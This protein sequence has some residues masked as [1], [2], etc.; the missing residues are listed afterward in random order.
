MKTTIAV[1][2]GTGKS[3]KYLVKQ[4]LQK[5]YTIRVL[6][7]NPE[8][9]PE[10]RPNQEI[11]LGD[12]RDVETVKAVLTGCDAVI[13]TLGLG[14]PAS[15]PTLFTQATENVLKTGIQRYIVTTG[16]NVDA[17]GDEKGPAAAMGTAWMKQN[18]PV[19]TENK[20]QEHNLLQ[21]SEIDWT[22]VRL[23]LIEETD[24]VSDVATSLT[25]CPGEKISA[26]NLA[27][28]LIQQL[29]STEFFRK[30]PFL[31]DK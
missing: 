9:A 22:M 10:T 21:A 5:G 4:L 26:T 30:A 15:E 6:V 8:R 19:S 20:Q 16:L 17:V 25:D 27:H 24:R 23:P 2:G 18:F 1:I 11:I 31:A 3:G 29:K 12:V 28:F 13:S 14:V 7:R